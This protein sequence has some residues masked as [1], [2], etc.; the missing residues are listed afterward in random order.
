MGYLPERVFADDVLALYNIHCFL[1]EINMGSGL[2]FLLHSTLSAD[3]RELRM[4]EQHGEAVVRIAY[5]HSHVWA[6]VPHMRRHQAM[7]FCTAHTNSKVVP[8]SA[9]SVD[10]TV[11]GYRPRH[12]F[13]LRM[14]VRE[15]RRPVGHIALAS[16]VKIA[17][18]IPAPKAP[19][20]PSDPL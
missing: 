10:T 1:D 9:Y 2:A 18:P 12:S 17:K 13:E 19:A 11:K 7:L 6:T 16:G 14:L 8:H 4:E 5:W 3:K 15:P 20:H